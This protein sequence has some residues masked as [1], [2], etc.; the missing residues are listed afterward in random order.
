MATFS[1]TEVIIIR[2]I[3]DVIKLM[4]T[5]LSTE[6]TWLRF[7]G[8]SRLNTNCYLA[9]EYCQYGDLEQHISSIS[10]ESEVRQITVNVLNGLNILHSEALLM[11]ISNLRYGRPY[12]YLA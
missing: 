6:I 4:L 10:S 2:R 1:A 8:G 9:I 7:L 12:S 5:W 11:V 3:L